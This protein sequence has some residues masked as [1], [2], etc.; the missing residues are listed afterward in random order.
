MDLVDGKT[1]KGKGKKNVRG[2]EKGYG[3]GEEE[4]LEAT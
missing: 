2:R 3:G 1:T 4:G